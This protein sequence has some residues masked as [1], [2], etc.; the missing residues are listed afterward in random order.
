MSSV[1]A[2]NTNVSLYPN[3]ISDE[4]KIYFTLNSTYNV[5][6]KISDVTGRVLSRQNFGKLTG[7]QSLKIG[8][9]TLTPGYYIAELRIGNETKSLPFTIK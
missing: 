7:T 1:L 9:N 3:P 6:L 8:A 2:K 4:S 5:D